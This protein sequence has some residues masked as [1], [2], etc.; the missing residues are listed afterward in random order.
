MIYPEAV[1][2]CNG[3]DDNCDGHVDEVA[4]DSDGDGVDDQ[5]DNCVFVPNTNQSDVDFDGRG[6][7]CDN[8]PTVANANQS[9]AD[10]D[11]FGDACDNCPNVPNAG[12][13][14]N[15]GDGFGDICDICPTVSNPDQN[16]AACDFCESLQPTL[17][18]TSPLGKGSGTLRWQTC[19]EGD[20]IGFNVVNFD[21]QGNRNQINPA[22]IPCQECSSGRGATYTTLIPKH[23][24][25]K[26][27]FIEMLLLN[28]QVQLFGPAIKE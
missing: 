18:L 10:A 24:S 15:D 1:E 25:G 21:N 23:R 19:F 26:N 11:G 20:V 2:V 9:D 22:V 4:C 12:Q 17:S 6:D 13:Q 14:D 3:V 28:G 8:C 16:P 7:V 5:V 27:I